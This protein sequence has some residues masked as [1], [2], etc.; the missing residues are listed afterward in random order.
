MSLRYRRY[1]VPAL[2]LIALLPALRANAEPWQMTGVDLSTRKVDLTALSAAGIVCHIGDAKTDQTIPWEAVVSLQHNTPSV[3]NNATFTLFLAGG[4]RLSGQPGATVGEKLN[5]LNPD[6]GTLKVPIAKIIALVAGSDAALPPAPASPPK[7]DIATLLNGDTIAGTFMESDAR[8]IVIQTDAGAIPI[9]LGSIKRLAFADIAPPARPDAP[10]LETPRFFRIH[11]LDSTIISAADIT[12][13]AGRLKMVMI[14]KNALT[15][16]LPL[17]NVSLIEQVDGPIQWLSAQSPLEQK[18]T[19]YF[20]NA[21]PWPAR[22]DRAVDGCALSFDGRMF[23][24]GIGV[25]AYS[26][27]TFAIA[28][29]WSAF[30][31]QYA[32]ESRRDF[33]SRIADVTVRILLDGKLVHEQK[34]LREGVI[35]PVVSFGVTGAKTLTLE[36]DFG[37][38]TGDAQAH[39]NWLEPAFLRNVP[40]GVSAGR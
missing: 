15:I 28:P 27:L 17:K 13:G 37:A 2:L 14:G 29:Q 30:R 34:D 4:D 5:W 38:V 6:L 20:G 32:I 12:L 9:P 10:Q 25:H 16:D 18:Q 19:P 23:Q 36:C 26:S 8:R 31:T 24:H 3:T 33:P 39:L 7:Q 40:A 1:F 11:L 21:L 22:F 35:S